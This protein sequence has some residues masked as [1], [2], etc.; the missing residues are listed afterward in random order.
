MLIIQTG[1]SKPNLPIA[2]APP[3]MQFN[4]NSRLCSSCRL[5]PFG[6]GTRVC[7]GELLATNRL[8]LFVANLIR[9]FHIMP[10]VDGCEISCDAR[11]YKY[12]GAMQPPHFQI[13]ALPRKSKESSVTP[14]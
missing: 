8:F 13:R 10:A 5:L 2:I 6:A 4:K 11:D 14:K 12:G 3:I 7:L 9:N 1:N